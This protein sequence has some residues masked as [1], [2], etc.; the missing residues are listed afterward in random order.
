M[1]LSGLVLD[2]YDDCGGST[3][4][5]IYPT[6]DDVPVTVKTAHALTDDERERLPDDVFALILDNGESGVLR[7]YACIDRGNTELAVAYFLQN[8]DK[9]PLEAQK[10]AA[11][12]LATACSWYEMIPPLEL[13]KVA[14]IG[15]I[16]GKIMG[17]AGAAIPALGTL[18]GLSGTA[19]DIS[20]GL[21]RAKQSRGL[22][23]PNLIKG[24]EVAGTPIMPLQESTDK[25]SPKYKTTVKNAAIGHL[26]QGKE[27]HPQSE[28]SAAL[29]QNRLHTEKNPAPL[30]QKQLKPY[31]N[32]QG[33]EPP[34][35]T[36]VK[37]SHYALHG[38]YPLDSFEQVKCASA[39]FDE[40][41]A[42]FSPEDRHEYCTNMVREADALRIPVS[43][44]ARKYGSSK[45]ASVEEVMLSLDTRRP[46]LQEEDT[47][48][49]SKLAA[50]M[51]T[52]DPE[53]F[54]MALSE[55]DKRV[56]LHH[57]YDSNVADPFFT[58]FGGTKV[59]EYS[60]SV[61]SDYVNED[62]LKEFA[63][64][65]YALLKKRFGEDIA[66]EFQKDPI[67][68]FESMPLEQKKVIS[69]LATDPQ[70]TRGDS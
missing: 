6:R 10:V 58:T 24:A 47:K 2:V 21:Q 68:I 29:A 28:R 20:G 16:G 50:A 48:L 40:Y 43:D 18:Q 3:L 22:I 1:H 14:G 34:S 32:V 70:P 19:S 59:A 54:A 67:G 65:G 55:F 52:V 66:N 42:R 56:G 17:V 36:K 33:A 44:M 45:Y 46:L 63:I 60:F 39:Y 15:Q 5:S 41:W 23:D 69:R 8:K 13:L 12:N 30:Q 31:V 38:R 57:Y 62:R 37:V 11:S 4:K 53:I 26:V 35:P 49:L 61:G 27:K 7:K 9:L 64:A 25:S 51:P